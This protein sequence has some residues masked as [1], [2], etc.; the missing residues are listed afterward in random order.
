[1]SDRILQTMKRLQE[2]QFAIFIVANCCA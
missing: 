1:M 2:I